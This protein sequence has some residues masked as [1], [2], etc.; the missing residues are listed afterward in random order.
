VAQAAEEP[1][2][3]KWWLWAGVG[4]AALLAGGIVYA[5]TAPDARP[6]TLGNLPRR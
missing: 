2:T 6:T 5:A 1:L 3:R 4:A